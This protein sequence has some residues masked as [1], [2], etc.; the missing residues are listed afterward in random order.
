MSLINSAKPN[1][2]VGVPGEPQRYPRTMRASSHQNLADKLGGAHLEQR[3]RRRDRYA[4]PKFFFIKTL[5]FELM[6]KVGG[7]T[8]D[9][10]GSD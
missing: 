9:V 7:A 6:Q 4:D 8:S 3:T 5:A 1:L 2:E 10:R